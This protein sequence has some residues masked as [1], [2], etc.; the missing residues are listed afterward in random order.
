MMKE[1]LWKYGVLILA[2]LSFIAPPVFAE[3]SEPARQTLKGITGVTVVVEDLQ[4]NLLKYEKFTKNFTLNKAQIQSDVEQ[5]LKNAGIRILSADEFKQTPGCPM[6]YVNIN[7]HENEKYWFAYD[8]RVELR[9]V[10]F[11]EANPQ[12]RSLTGTWTMNITGVANIGNLDLIRKD[13]GALTDRF[14]QALAAVN[15]K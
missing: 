2:L 1:Q 8:I 9:Q 10:V 7:T 4:P 11:L 15:R 12:I 14:I 3:D 5:R 6:L 13:V